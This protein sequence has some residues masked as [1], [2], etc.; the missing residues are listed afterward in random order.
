EESA[1]AI[2]PHRALAGPTWKRWHVDLGLEA[3]DADLRH[4]GRT[5][6]G[7][8]VLDQEHVGAE[9]HALVASFYHI[10]H[11]AERH[12]PP[13]RQAQLRPNDDDIVELEVLAFLD[14]DPE[15]ESHGVLG[16][17]NSS[18]AHE[19]A[20]AREVRSNR[21]IHAGSPSPCR[22]W[23]SSAPTGTRFCGALA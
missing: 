22:R 20:S 13:A 5:Y 14:R 16:T 3:G 4:P 12:P 7:H 9:L 17:E 19:A 18:N 10:D 1:L 8:R 15:L 23:C 2:V 21:R 11:P 6:R